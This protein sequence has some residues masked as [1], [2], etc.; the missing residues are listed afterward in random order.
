MDTAAEFARHF[1]CT[2]GELFDFE[3]GE[4]DQVGNADCELLKLFNSMSKEERKALLAVANGLVE[5]FP[6]KRERE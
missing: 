6:A 5:A 2:I 3:E 1:K 4:A